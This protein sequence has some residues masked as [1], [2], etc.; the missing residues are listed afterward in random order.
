MYDISDG[1]IWDIVRGTMTGPKGKTFIDLGS[2]L[3]SI[4]KLTYG[5]RSKLS[6]NIL[7]A[8]RK[9]GDYVRSTLTTGGFT[10]RNKDFSEGLQRISE[11]NA[12]KTEYLLFTMP[13]FYNILVRNLHTN[14]IYSYGDII[15]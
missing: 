14:K 4:V 5:N 6:M 8:S 1:I 12:P 7:R 9:N 11:C 2:I 15:G 3:A 10:K 13:S